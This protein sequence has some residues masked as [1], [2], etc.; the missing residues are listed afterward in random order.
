MR[1][2]GDG[3]SIQL[4]KA[5]HPDFFRRVTRESERRGDGTLAKT[6]RELASERLMQ[7]EAAAA[8]PVVPDEVQ[9]EA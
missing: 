5:N 7:I 8:E 1:S 2:T 4:R 6:V 3:E 9:A